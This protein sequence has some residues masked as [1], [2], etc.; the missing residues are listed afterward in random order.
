MDI[1]IQ[2][3][4]RRPASVALEG[5]W[6]DHQEG[7]IV[8]VFEVL[9]RI[10]EQLSSCGPALASELPNGLQ[11]V[12]PVF[13]QAARNTVEIPQTSRGRLFQSCDKTV[14]DWLA[15]PHENRS[16]RIEILHENDH[17]FVRAAS[18]FARTSSEGKAYVPEVAV[19]PLPDCRSRI[20]ISGCLIGDFE[21]G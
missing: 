1:R 16:I 18:C 19:H 7:A 13:R 3:F 10:P 15:L 20:V 21:S 17:G 4:R 8:F 9:Q 11:I 6:T 2:Q 12:V 14:H 5:E